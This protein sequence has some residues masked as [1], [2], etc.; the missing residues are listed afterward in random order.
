MDLHVRSEEARRALLQLSRPPPGQPVAGRAG[1]PAGAPDRRQVERSP[2]SG[3][4]LLECLR[5]ALTRLGPPIAPRLAVRA[6]HL[7][8][9]GRHALQRAEL[10]ARHGALVLD[11]QAGGHVPVPPS[12]EQQGL[13]DQEAVVLPCGPR[14]GHPSLQHAPQHLGA[15]RGHLVPM[16]EAAGRG[17]LE[18]EPVEDVVLLALAEPYAPA[19][20]APPEVVDGPI[21]AD[22]EE[23]LLHRVAA[24]EARDPAH[25]AEQRLLQDVL[26]GGGVDHPASHER[27]QA[28]GVARLQ[29]GPL[30]VVERLQP[31]DVELVVHGRL[32]RPRVSGLR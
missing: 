19:D 2:P 15:M 5:P 17:C 8:G 21:A 29:R 16:H 31:V 1:R 14:L 3:S 28:L 22:A 9:Q 12:R 13:D 23:V 7:A 4:Q 6:R 25:G 18:G 20:A 30:P 11:P 10:D 24:I 27:E 32:M 26:A